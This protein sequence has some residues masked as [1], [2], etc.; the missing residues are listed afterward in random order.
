[1][2]IQDVDHDKIS[3]VQKKRQIRSIKNRRICMKCCMDVKE[4]RKAFKDRNK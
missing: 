2:A 1:M 3:D 4:T